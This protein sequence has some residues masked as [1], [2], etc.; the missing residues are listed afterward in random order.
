MKLN[1]ILRTVISSAIV[2]LSVL[3]CAGGAGAEPAGT[4]R[5]ALA[6]GCEDFSLKVSG[7]Y[8]I[9]DQDTGKVLAESKQGEKLQVEL[10]GKRISVSGSRVSYGSF[11]GPVIVRGAS[12]SAAVIN[13]G[14]KVA[15]LSFEKLM[16][17]TGDG[18]TVSLKSSGNPTVRSSSGT[19]TLTGGG[20][21]L[22]LVSLTS[23]S[24]SKRY[25]G[26]MEFR[27]EDGKLTAVNVLN[28]ED[29]LRGVVPAEMPAYWPEEALKAQ[30]VAARNY[31]LQRVETSRGSSFNVYCDI[32]SQVYGG[33]DAESSSTSKAIEET[34]GVVMLSGGETAAAFFHSSSGGYTENSE[35]VWSGKVPYIK[36]KPDPYDKN[37]NY[38]NWK[39]SYTTKQLKDNLAAAG[40]KFNKITAIN[41]LARTSSGARVKEL[42]VKGEGAAGKP[43]TVEISNADN[44]R[45]ALDLKS[46]LFK[47]TRKY[48]S[49]KNLAGVEITGSGWGHGLGMSQYGARGMAQKGYNYQEILK[50]Y[51]SGVVLAEDY[52]R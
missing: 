26:D 28:I 24:G 38:Y 15:E 23:A 12:S 17:V 11:K 19:V 43:L 29:Y 37:D 40:Y 52:G 36:S 44:V 25:R 32:S 39:V 46:S 41:E 22:N 10:K 9:V 7:G 51:Y 5:V 3:I 6:R 49:K 50:Y 42:E 18:R 45:I 8:E 27:L 33:Y 2:M 48:D 47:L 20:D 16:A 34:K 35:D 21:G 4:I 14:G 13:A 30:A 1:I 31:A